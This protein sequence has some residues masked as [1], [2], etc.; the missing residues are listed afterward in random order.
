LGTGD[1]ARKATNF[2]AKADAK[3][4][5][6]VYPDGIDHHWNDGRKNVNARIDDIGFV[7]QLI[8]QLTS[9]LP[10]DSSRIYAA[11]L[12]NGGHFA[13]RLGCELSE[14][15]AGI[16]TDIGPMPAEL[17]Q[18]CK[19]ARPVGLIGI[20]GAADPITPVGGGEVASSPMFGLG[21]GG[22][23]ESAERTM[24]FW[25]SANGCDARPSMIHEPPRVNDGTS[26]DKY[27]YAGCRNGG[28][29][30]YYIV[31][32]MGHSW[33]PQLGPVPQ[34]TGPTSNNINA[35]DRIWDFFSTISR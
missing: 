11:G 16:G 20:Q 5:I 3:G 27:I 1:R 21:K 23:V 35:T 28:P 9:Q 30:V 22:K 10:I 32:G 15:L 24:E 26:V 4:F 7:R 13:L 19:P 6:V 33:P 12:S 17:M 31:R 8:R 34:I 25:A 14:L 18:V 2:D 29:V